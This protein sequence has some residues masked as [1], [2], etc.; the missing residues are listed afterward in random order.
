MYEII[1][2]CRVHDMVSCK[3]ILASGTSACVAALAAFASASALSQA[4]VLGQTIDLPAVTGRL[5]HLDIDLEGNRLFVAAL[6]AGSLEVI[7]LRTGKRIGRFWPLSTPQGVA[8]LPARHRV[9][10]A[11]GGSGRVEAYDGAPSAVAS[12]GNLDD[13]DNLRVDPR[14][15]RLFVGYGRAWRSSIRRPW[16][17]RDGSSCPDIPRHS[18]SNRRDPACSS[19]CR[20]RD[21]S[22]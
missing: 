7:D 10:V 17:S 3:R 4:L 14:A 6:A 12:V 1:H 19:T 18:S 21:K 5:D 9:V 11:S 13:A 8:Y 22:S 15:D 20:A 2:S 16:R